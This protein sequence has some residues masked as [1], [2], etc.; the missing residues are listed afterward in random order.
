[1]EGGDILEPLRDRIVGRISQEDIYDP[2]TGDK[3]AKNEE[4]SDELVQCLSGS[5]HRAAKIRSTCESRLTCE[6]VAASA[7]AATATTWPASQR[8]PS[9]LQRLS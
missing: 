7:A 3:L 9:R 6:T 8:A 4:L 1:M 5:G 2:L